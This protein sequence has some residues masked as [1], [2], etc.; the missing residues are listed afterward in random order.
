M[1]LVRGRDLVTGESSG[2]GKSA[3]FLGIAYALDCLPSGFTAKA[4]KNFFTDDDLQV[5][6]TLDIDGKEVVV[7]RGKETS[8]DYGDR[9]VAG[10]KAYAEELPKLVKLP[11]AFLTALTYRPQDTKGLFVSMGPSDKIEF[12]IELLGLGQIVTE[13]EKAEKAEKTLAAKVAELQALV[14]ACQKSLATVQEG[15]PVEPVV[16]DPLAASKLEM[17]RKTL[18]SVQQEQAAL[19]VQIKEHTKDQTDAVDLKIKEI[20]REIAQSHNFIALLLEADRTRQVEHQAQSKI[21]FDD[22]LSMQSQIHNL[23]SLQEE[24]KKNL[25]QIQ[26]L[27]SNKCPTCDQN[28]TEAQEKLD[29]LRSQVEMKQNALEELPRL[30]ELIKTLELPKQ[31][32]PDPRI[33]AFQDV[34]RKLLEDKV[35][36]STTKIEVP[37]ELWDT[38]AKLGQQVAF[39]EKAILDTTAVVNRTSI[40]Q[41]LFQKQLARHQKTLETVQNDLEGRKKDLKAATVSLNAERDFIAAMGKQGFLGRIVE[42]V[43]FEIS[44]EATKWLG[45]LANANRM[46]VVFSTETEKGRQQIQLL[47]DV[48]GNRVKPDAVLSGGQLT[49]LAQAVDLAV[50]S[51]ISRRRGGV[52]PGWLCL[53]EIFNGQGLITKES[54][55]EIIKELSTD[56]LVLVIDHGTETAETFSRTINIEFNEGI[57]K[58]AT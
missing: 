44:D 3:V 17:Y 58:V 57:S 43:L 31:F 52:V 30:R 20:D 13:V 38:N 26:K 56:R 46:G 8:I 51:V 14:D 47:V 53:D 35:A 55:L 27:Q 5:T 49:S 34:S 25:D 6:L 15:R 11:L 21:V 39:L 45:R 24:V 18:D 2:T 16:V 28:W 33:K 50:M 1:V 22:L 32:K 54:A 4:L 37:P 19:F 41:E 12:L 10:A 29:K 7:S 36:V 48:R 9:K 40:E 23:E 42:E